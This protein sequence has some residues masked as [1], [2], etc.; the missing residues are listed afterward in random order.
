MSNNA[1]NSQSEHGSG[2]ALNDTRRD[3]SGQTRPAIR[4][5]Q[6]N[7]IQQVQATTSQPSTIPQQGATTYINAAQVLP[8]NALLINRNQEGNPLLPYIRQISKQFGDIIPDYQVGQDTAVLFISLRF[9]KLKPNHIRFRIK[10]IG[11]AFRSYLLCHVDVDDPHVPLMDITK[12]AIDNRLTLICGFSN[13]ECARY[14]ETLKAFEN[15]PVDSIKE[16]LQDD[17]Q[18]RVAEALTM[19]RGV[20]RTD[21]ATMGTKFGTVAD[22][23]KADIDKLSSCPGLGPAKAKRLFEAFNSPF[24]TKKVVIASQPE[25]NEVNQ[26]QI[27]EDIG[28]EDIDDDFADIL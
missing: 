27:V 12:L 4:I 1:S 5:P 18:S 15:K 22:I 2:Q 19:V 11:H 16:R 28:E 7:E 3:G 9:H 8:S 6:F 21:C 26:D 10:Q 23:L 20:N 14:L 25:S 17:H 24:T 13:R